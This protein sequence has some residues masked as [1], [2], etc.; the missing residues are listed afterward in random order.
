MKQEN[1][2]KSNVSLAFIKRFARIQ[3]ND[4]QH[5]VASQQKGAPQAA[6]E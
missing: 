4:T 5:R 6:A 2:K 3:P 1:L